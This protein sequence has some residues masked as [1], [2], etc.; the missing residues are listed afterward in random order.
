[1]YKA[2]VRGQQKEFVEL[3]SINKETGEHEEPTAG[4]KNNESIIEEERDLNK[5]EEDILK[6]FRQNDQEL[7]EIA[8]TIVEELK[9]VKMNA[10]NIEAG[11]DE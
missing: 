10:E 5:E 8:S 2:R 6:A 3:F 11:I 4:D 9:K 1:M 7:E